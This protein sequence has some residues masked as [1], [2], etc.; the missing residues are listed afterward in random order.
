M[1]RAMEV[2]N[3]IA[4]LHGLTCIQVCNLTAEEHFRAHQHLQA[5]RVEG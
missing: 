4:S 3:L 2:V 1:P 5:F